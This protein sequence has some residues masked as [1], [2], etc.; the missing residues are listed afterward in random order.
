ME[1]HALR[2]ATLMVA[3][4]QTN[5]RMSCSLSGDPSLVDPGILD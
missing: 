3:Q 1:Y 2:T 5:E 4:A